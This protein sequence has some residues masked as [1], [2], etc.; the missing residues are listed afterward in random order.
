MK[1]Y[2][3]LLLTLVISIFSYAAITNHVSEKLLRLFK[4][5]YPN[6]KEVSWS[7][8][9]ETYIVNF[10][11]NGIRSRITYEKSGAYQSS[12]RYYGEEHLLPYL[13]L[14][15][16]SNFPGKK[17]FGVTEVSTAASVDYFVKMED[18]GHWTTIKIDS[19]ANW[20]LVEELEKA[21]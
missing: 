9:P 4:E 13:V 19:D 14:Y 16:K 1:K 6:A 21:K 7:E 3:V 8:M 2:F 15:L 18:S 10:V 5:A 11:E 17:I 12:I 20:K